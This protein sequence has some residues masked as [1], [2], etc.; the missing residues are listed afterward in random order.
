MI[1]L[2]TASTTPVIQS[3][4]VRQGTHVIAVGACRPTHREMDPKLVARARLIVDSRAAALK[5]SG[6]VVLGIQEG[7]FGPEHVK[8]ELGEVI[9][10]SCKGRDHTAQITI[11]KSLGLA[12]EDVAAA[13]LVFHL[14]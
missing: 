3:E 7:L 9:S 13:D 5:E 12:C 14:L 2:V 10:G 8:G 1:A 6:D 4:W 11:F